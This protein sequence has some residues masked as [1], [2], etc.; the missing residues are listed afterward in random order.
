MY[1]VKYQNNW[2][3]WEKAESP[4]RLKLDRYATEIEYYSVDFLGNT[5]DTRSEALIIPLP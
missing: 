2:G 3:E 1:R 4:L 5:E